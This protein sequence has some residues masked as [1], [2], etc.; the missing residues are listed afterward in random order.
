M[1][2][3]KP[4]H[5]I[6]WK[7]NDWTPASETPAAHPNAR[8]TA[9]ARQCPTIDP[10]WENPEG[11][12]ISAFIF[13]GRLAHN[14]PLVYQSFNWSHGVY[15]AATMGSEKTAAAEG[16]GGIRR[17]PFAMLP[18]C[19]YNMAD[20]WSHWLEMKRLA[21][22]APKIFRVNWFR[23]DENG[24]FMWPGYGDNLRVLKWIID[25]VHDRVGA[26]EG[27]VGL[28]PYYKDLDL[29]GLDY[30]EE[31]FKDLMAID[32]AEGLKDTEDQAKY[33]R[34]FVEQQRLPKEFIS[35]LSLLSLR[36]ERSDE[37]W[38]PV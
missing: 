8:F 12:P 20:Y 37:E 27:P 33:F 15:L 11:V 31:K 38:K 7:G 22:Y 1:T 18:F 5:L 30:T 29:T 13:G 6:D 36:F 34:P 19:G 14:T 26:Q 32:K 2:D 17:D 25:R 28:M 23:K 24:H 10:D 3:E 9:P 16:A 21:P 35:E 4:A